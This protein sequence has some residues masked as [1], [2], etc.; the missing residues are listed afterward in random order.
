MGGTSGETTGSTWA[1]VKGAGCTISAPT[2]IGEKGEAIGET[3]EDDGK[4]VVL[5]TLGNAA[6]HVGAT[7]LTGAC[8]NAGK[9]GMIG[10]ACSGAATGTAVASKAGIS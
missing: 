9:A 6:D 2:G 4:D 1:G 7:A 5:G 8:V 10:R 3:D